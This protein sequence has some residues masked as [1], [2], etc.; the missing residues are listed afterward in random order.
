MH[1]ISDF[2]NNKQL[3]NEI[4]KEIRLFQKNKR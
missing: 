4:N 2:F 1:I 3:K